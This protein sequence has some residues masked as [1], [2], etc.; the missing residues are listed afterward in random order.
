MNVLDVRTLLITQM[1][2][3]ALCTGVMA[4][5]WYQNRR[6]F[7]GL[8]FWLA[9]S[10]LQTLGILLIVLR[11]IAPDWLSVVAGNVL[12]VTGPFLLYVGLERFVGHRSSQFH[13]GMLL[14]TF[15]LLHA[16]FTFV[17]PSLAARNI[18]VSAAVIVACVQMAW[19]LL[20]RVGPEM[21]SMTRGI[22]FLVVAYCVIS[23]AR[24]LVNALG[25]RETTSCITSVCLMPSWS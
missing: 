14:L 17:Q 3:Y 12:L 20:G 2:S 6:R 24:I 19:L 15:T 22:G 16:Y 8:G 11:G 23:V 9:N 25:R 10:V 7:A 13:N 4:L 5:L 1:L 18:N 21:R